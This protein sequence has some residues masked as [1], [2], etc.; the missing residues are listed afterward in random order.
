VEQSRQLVFDAVR[1]ANTTSGDYRRSVA[2]AAL[3]KLLPDS[4]LY[5][6]TVF[7]YYP[8]AIDAKRHDIVIDAIEV[9]NTIMDPNRRSIAL[10][11]ILNSIPTN[12]YFTSVVELV[13]KLPME[14]QQRVIVDAIATANAIKDQKDRSEALATLESYISEGTKLA[15]LKL[16]S[17]MS[18]KRSRKRT[19]N[20]IND[21]IDRSEALAT[22]EPYIPERVNLRSY[23]SRKRRPSL[24]LEREDNFS[25]A[26]FRLEHDLDRELEASRTIRIEAMRARALADLSARLPH[27]LFPKALRIILAIQDPKHRAVALAALAP[28]LP[29]ALLGEALQGAKSNRRRQ[30]ACG[31]DN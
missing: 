16:A 5:I 25:M 11:V 10:A 18:R 2:R 30:T 13:P 9:A 26:S 29:R 31:C 4:L 7:E 21:S 6:R 14:Y 17:L 8:Q 22:L 1:I 12:E 27:S 3:L 28:Q 23:L 19:A 20:A 24:R 15:S